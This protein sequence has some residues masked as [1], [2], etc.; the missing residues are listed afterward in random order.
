MEKIDILNRDPDVERLQNIIR[1]IS[2][3]KSNTSFAIN[4][5]WGS[6]KTFVLNMLE[7]SLEQVQDEDTASNRYLIFHYDCWKYDYYEEPIL[8]IVASMLD[9]LDEKINVLSEKQRETVKAALKTI[10][11]TF[12]NIANTV[13]EAKTGIDFKDTI[14]SAKKVCGSAKK[15]IEVNH[16]YDTYFSFN[17]T[18]NKLRN[19]IRGLSAD[20]TIVFVVDELDRCLPSYAIKVL[21]RLHH[22]TNE[23]DNTVTIIATDKKRLES[24]INSTI[25]VTEIDAYLKKF[26]KFEVALGVGDTNNDIEKKFPTY[27]SLF[28]GDDKE[29]AMEYIH[30]FFQN[31][32]IRSISR[33]IELAEL[34]HTI[35][36]KE[37]M[38]YSVMCM[39][40]F[41]LISIYNYKVGLKKTTQKKKYIVSRNFLRTG[42][43]GHDWQVLAKRIFD[44]LSNKAELKNW[45]ER[46]DVE[47]NPYHELFVYD[48]SIIYDKLCYYYSILVGGCNVRLDN[49]MI[50]DHKYPRIKEYGDYIALFANFITLIHHES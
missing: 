3:K 32:D 43:Q 6:G 35:L 31:I 9:T 34:T 45:Y 10:G 20:H 29:E 4:G 16:D 39:E 8:A 49:S 11:N 27:F 40:V 5:G 25:G 15:S 14:K 12:L 38:D 47:G 28:E 42:S 48:N 44:F 13:V 17:K 23:L 33:I 2:E 37:K 7:E 21:E 36:A 46:V 26:I 19:T 18:L 50:V 1:I 22:I 41:V 24:I 30:A